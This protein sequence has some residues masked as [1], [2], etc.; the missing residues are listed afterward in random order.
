MK[1]YC[2]LPSRSL[3]RRAWQDRVSQNNTR[4]A[5]PRQ[6]TRP[7]PIFW[8]QTGLVLRPTVSDHI[9]GTVWPRTT[10]FGKVTQGGGTYFYGS[11]T[12][13][14]QGAGVPTSPKLLG[15][16]HDHTAWPTTT[17]F[18]MVTHAGRVACFQAVST[19]PSKWTGPEHAPKFVGPPA[20]AHTVWESA[21]KFCMVVKKDVRKI[22]GTRMLTRALFVIAN[23]LVLMCL[24]LFLGDH[25]SD[26]VYMGLGACV[27]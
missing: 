19:P 20:C 11:A 16:T 27:I 2:V 10:A 26:Y 8:S 15:P 9:T 4:P 23:L 1:S 13:P 17:K 6:R 12:P 7:R 21:T 22:L 5:R 25:D 24:Q 14:S 18:R 3:R